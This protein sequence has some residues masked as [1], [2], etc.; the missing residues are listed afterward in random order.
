M[1]VLS[2]VGKKLAALY[3]AMLKAYREAQDKEKGARAALEIYYANVE[4]IEEFSRI[5]ADVH[6]FKNVLEESLRALAEERA[7]DER[8]SRTIRGRGCLVVKLVPCGKHCSGCPHGPYAYE[9]HKIG[10]RQVW[11]YLGR[12]P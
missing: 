3:E 2:E 12:A 10:G 11:K 5:L 7:K 6:D 8:G 1:I 9:V 4:A